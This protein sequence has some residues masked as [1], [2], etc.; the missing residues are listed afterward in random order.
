MV[1]ISTV[2]PLAYHGIIS[3]SHGSDPSKPGLIARFV[4]NELVGLLVGTRETVGKGVMGARVTRAWVGISV[5]DTLGSSDIIHGGSEYKHRTP[6]SRILLE[7]Q[8]DPPPGRLPHPLPP[9]VPHDSKQH[10][11]LLNTSCGHDPGESGIDVCGLVVGLYDGLYD[12]L[13]LVGLDVV[14]CLDGKEVGDR[15]V[16][17]RVGI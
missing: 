8:F 5:G 2:P 16:G 14:G 9:Q 7:Q 15:L 4:D 12:G 1:S 13:R 3:S 17:D 6:L 10:I 11:S